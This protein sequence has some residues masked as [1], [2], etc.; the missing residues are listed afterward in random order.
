M[1]S[2]FPGMDPCIEDPE[3]WSDFHGDLAAEVRAHLN[4][5]IQPRYV[6][7]LTPRVTYEEVEFAQPGGARPDVGVWQPRP[8]ARP[9]PQAVALARPAPVESAVPLELPIR[10]Y[11]V[12]VHEVET[13]VLVAAIE[14]LSPVNKRRGHET[15]LAYRRKRQRLLRAEVHLLEIDLLRAGER[16]P[17][18]RPVPPAPYYAVLSRAG[19][20]PKA[21]VWPI[22]LRDPLPSLPVPLLAPDPDASLDLGAV[23]AAVYERGAYAA[24]IDYRR[25]PPPPEIPPE[26]AAWLDEHLR[27]RGAR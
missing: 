18:A 15:F 16:P 5:A 3:I 4:R 26:D 19:E 21:H 25:P 20:R 22:Q 2:P 10:L 13:M 9:A 17:L 11:T 27:A 12:E 7:R 23:V 8:A 14:I 24:Q 6:A 1:P